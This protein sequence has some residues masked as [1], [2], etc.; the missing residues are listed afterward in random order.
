[1]LRHYNNDIEG[2]A[3]CFLVQS[4]LIVGISYNGYT[5]FNTSRYHYIWLHTEPWFTQVTHFTMITRITHFPQV[6]LITR[7][8]M[9]TQTLLP[10]YTRL[11]RTTQTVEL[12]GT[13]TDQS[14]TSILVTWHQPTN[15]SRVSLLMPSGKCEVFGKIVINV[16]P[17]HRPL[18][19]TYFDHVVLC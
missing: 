15:Q 5:C 10:L 19:R 3:F 13:S 8:T 18:R 1:M 16:L 17:W 14:Q 11:V 4:R 9:A 7:V 2:H 12:V 6:R